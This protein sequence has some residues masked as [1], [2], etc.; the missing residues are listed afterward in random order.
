MRIETDM[1]KLCIVGA[2]PSGLATAKV[3]AE[4][5][6]P[7]DWLER[8]NDL[9]GIWNPAT[10]SGV[11]YETTHLLSSRFMTGFEVFPM[12]EDYPVYPSHAEVLRYFRAFAERFDLVRRIEFGAAVQR[13]ERTRGGWSVRV[14]G[15]V[16][17]RFYRALVVASGHHHRP[18][19]PTVP[20]AFA[21]EI[22]HSRDYRSPKQ[23]IDKRVVVV[24]AG[25]SGC[26]IVVD[27]TG[28]ART[29]TH[30]M[31]RGVYFVPKFM[32]GFP[33]DRFVN[34]MEMIPMPFGVRNR[35]Y[36]VWNALFV[37][38]HEKLGLQKPDHRIL[39]AHP[40]MNS[41]MPQLIA[42][43]R[44]APKPDLAAF[45][46]PIVRFIDGSEVEADLVIFA[47]GYD[48]DVPF[49]DAFE[50][51]EPDGD[52]KLFLNVFDP[53]SDDLFAVGLIQTNGSIW[54][55]SEAQAQL[56][57]SSIIASRS[58]PKR[59]QW[60][61]KLKARGAGRRLNKHHVSS[62][63]HRL[64]ANHHTYMREIRRLLRGFGPSAGARLPR[65]PTGAGGRS[66]LD[67]RVSAGREPNQP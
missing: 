19:M 28:W 56:I 58:D 2:G 39:Q 38:P 40:T 12:P 8:E 30:S 18:R 32:F 33:T 6:I 48:S 26:D 22:I 34:V 43:G 15:E 42:H 47:T 4:R 54:R 20:G 25:N 46:G 51:F 67:T 63:R 10:A 21:G 24:G 65:S 37:G 1:D 62:P 59:T 64:E 9:G 7:F 36:T 41:L 50:L 27:A 31:R 16:R 35:L 61:T 52:P 3:F 29:V 44:V 60:F 49:M 11:V 13:A 45:D 57:A 14:A 23:L 53:A 66:D 55:T 5:G 17:P